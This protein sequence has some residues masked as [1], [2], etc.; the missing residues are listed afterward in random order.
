MNANKKEIIQKNL[1]KYKGKPLVFK[2]YGYEYAMI[3][4]E[5]YL[6]LMH[7]AASLSDYYIV[8]TYCI[9]M[10]HPTRKTPTPIE[11]PIES[12]AIL[13]GIQSVRKMTQNEMNEYKKCVHKAMMKKNNTNGFDYFHP[14]NIFNSEDYIKV[15]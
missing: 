6:S 5:L 7:S 11:R 2:V 14:S 8:G 1:E 9:V 4:K 3:F 13:N 10:K 12:Y 15:I